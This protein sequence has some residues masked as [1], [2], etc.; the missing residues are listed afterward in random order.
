MLTNCCDMNTT[1][2]AAMRHLITIY[3]QQQE[4]EI[5]SELQLTIL[6]D[7]SHYTVICFD[8][9]LHN[10]KLQRALYIFYVW[11]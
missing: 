2:Q 7:H 5:N 8:A 11:R 4:L 10:I 1:Q 3:T 6:S 9:F